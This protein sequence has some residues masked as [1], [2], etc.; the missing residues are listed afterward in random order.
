MGWGKFMGH[1]G[2]YAKA[3]K[4]SAVMSAAFMEKRHITLSPS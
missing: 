2:N 3:A 4:S 1:G